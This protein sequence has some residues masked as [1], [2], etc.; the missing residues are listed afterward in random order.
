M[1]DG[2]YVGR[3]EMWGCIAEYIGLSRGWAKMMLLDEA[4]GEQSECGLD[5]G[6]CSEGIFMR[7]EKKKEEKSKKN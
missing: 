1:I 5:K 4:L 7:A 2:S 6:T 3:E